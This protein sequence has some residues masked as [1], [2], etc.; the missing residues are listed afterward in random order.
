M[1]QVLGLLHFLTVLRHTLKHA[2][3][4][5]RIVIETPDVDSELANCVFE[6]S[7]LAKQAGSQLLTLAA[8][9]PTNP[10]V[11]RTFSSSSRLKP[12]NSF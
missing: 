10:E 11:V 8:I 4:E 6:Y 9:D 7:K 5:N 1:P 3:L 2:R 12:R